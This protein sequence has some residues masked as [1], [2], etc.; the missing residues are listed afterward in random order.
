[1]EKREASDLHSGFLGTLVLWKGQALDH[2]D[3]WEVIALL[4][5]KN[6]VLYT[7]LVLLLFLITTSITLGLISKADLSLYHE[8]STEDYP[9]K[10]GEQTLQG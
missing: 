6:P 10:L 7:N 4:Q 2:S 9:M 5:I 1:M 3:H 8:D